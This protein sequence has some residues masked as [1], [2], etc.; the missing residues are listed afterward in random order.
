MQAQVRAGDAVRYIRD[1]EVWNK[2]PVSFC[3]AGFLECPAQPLR[4]WS[5][6]KLHS[7]DV[8]ILTYLGLVHARHQAQPTKK[9]KKKKKGGVD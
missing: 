9:K 4:A 3:G 5:S 8:E 6:E 2:C 7:S 1:E